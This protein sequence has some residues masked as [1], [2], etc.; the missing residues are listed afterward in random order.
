MTST[1]DTT[2][3]PDVSEISDLTEGLLPP[4]RTAA[5]RTH[6]DACPLCS[7]VRSSL[8]EIR[9]LLGTLPGPTRMPA[10]VAGR[11]D[12]ALAAEALL[13]ATA[14]STADVSR[15][16][17][18]ADEPSAGESTADVATADVPRETSATAPASTTASDEQ[19]RSGAADRPA[20]RSAAPTAPGGTAGPGRGQRSARR[21]RRAVLGAV[22]G[23]AAVGMSVFVLQAIQ[24]ADAP[25]TAA[26]ADRSAASAQQET[27]AGAPV[28]NQV[29]ELLA[30]AAK[31]SQESAQEGEAERSPRSPRSADAPSTFRTEGVAVPP[32]VQEGTGRSETALAARQGS[33]QGSA[34]YLVVM[35]H[36]RDPKL[37]QAY[38][39]DASCTQLPD[40]DKAAVLLTHDYPRP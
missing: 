16:T 20:G 34:A 5:V 23:V 24:P 38:V 12:A 9:G 14:P 28:G 39:M 4:S 21:R 25:P 11:I 26:R 29:R 18:P 19:P 6:V 36:A 37:V 30:P 15:E 31:S 7:D 40:G 27:F 17:T 8:E 2:R 33:Y 3:H 35:P 13:D 22:F 32:C 10:D 1:T